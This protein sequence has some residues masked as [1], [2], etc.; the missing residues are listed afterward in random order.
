MTLKWH[1]MAARG[2]P[3]Q[4]LSENDAEMTWKWHKMA[5]RGMPRQ[6]GFNLQAVD[7][8]ANQVLLLI[9]LVIDEEEVDNEEER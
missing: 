9:S 7:H 1:E 4:F 5:A 3:R 8:S 2:M 6:F